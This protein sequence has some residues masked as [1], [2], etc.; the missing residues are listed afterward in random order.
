MPGKWGIGGED[1]WLRDGGIWPED[2]RS[3][4]PDGRTAVAINLPR[5]LLFLAVGTHISPT[6]IFQTRADLG[7]HTVNLAT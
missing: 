4:V 1:F 6:L 5:K 7:S 2:Y 3:G